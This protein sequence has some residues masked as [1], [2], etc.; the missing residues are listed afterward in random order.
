MAN[1]RLYH[2]IR[3]LETRVYRYDRMKSIDLISHISLQCNLDLM[4]F[5][6]NGIRELYNY[7]QE[8]GT[9]L[10]QTLMVYIECQKSYLNTANRF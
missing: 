9:N 2:P 1:R 6:G 8:N 7:D 5:V 3:S 4:E 10:L